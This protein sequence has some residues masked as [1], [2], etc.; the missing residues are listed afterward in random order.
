[1]AR[2]SNLETA[3]APL[4][5]LAALAESVEPTTVRTGRNRFGGINNPYIPIVRETFEEDTKE[6]GSGWRK[7]RL[8]ASQVREFAAAIRNA[9]TFLA[10]ENIGLRIKYEFRTDEDGEYNGRVI[11]IGDLS[12]VPTDDRPVDVKYTGRTKKQYGANDEE[13]EEDEDEID[14]EDAVEAS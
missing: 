3:N 2:K 8:P 5:D 7:N 10:D 4:L 14:D 6:T 13:A 9:T 12:K 11:E 1:M